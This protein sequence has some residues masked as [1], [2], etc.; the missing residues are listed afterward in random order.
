MIEKS[1][2]AEKERGLH[3]FYIKEA[4]RKVKE[5]EK[6]KMLTTTKKK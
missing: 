5:G 3:L 2:K 1:A 4:S 6:K